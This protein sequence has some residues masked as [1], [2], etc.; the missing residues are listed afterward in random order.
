M[1]MPTALRIYPRF[2]LFVRQR[3]SRPFG[4][5]GTRSHD[6]GNNHRRNR[7]QSRASRCLSHAI[8]Y[9]EDTRP[10]SAEKTPR[11]VAVEQSVVLLRAC[12]REVFFSCSTA[13]QRNAVASWTGSLGTGY[14]YHA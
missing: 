1:W 4:E 7:Q 14:D 8:T 2:N 13:S 5:L 3:S 9:L 11:I 6:A 10:L 12:T